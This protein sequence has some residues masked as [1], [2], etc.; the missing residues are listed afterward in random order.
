MTTTA[1]AATETP[2]TPTPSALEAMRAAAHLLEAMA[3]ATD[4]ELRKLAGCS[5]ERIALRAAIA[6]E[7]ERDKGRREA[8]ELVLRVE[9][10]IARLGSA[11]TWGADERERVA[12]W[13]RAELESAR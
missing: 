9:E 12:K 1:P 13:A 5:A 8:A 11:G 10:R 7:A 2:T 4:R 6:A 3:G